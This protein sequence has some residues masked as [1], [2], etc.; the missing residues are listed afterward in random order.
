MAAHSLQYSIYL[1]PNKNLKNGQ[2]PY[3]CS[4]KINT[5]FKQ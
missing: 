4:Q 3:K 2:S 1:K 5:L